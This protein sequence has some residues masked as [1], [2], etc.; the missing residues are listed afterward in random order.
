MKL[1]ECKKLYLEAKEA[2][3]LGNPIM[4][5]ATFDR[6]ENWISS[7]D[8][9]WE[10]LKKTG[11]KI[12]KKVEVEL[13]FFMPS[14]DKRYENIDEWF[15]KNP[16]YR[17]AYM[18][19]L[20]GCSVLLEYVKGKPNRL[21]TR[22]DGEHGKDISYFLPYLNIPG[23]IKHKKPICFRCEAILTKEDYAKKW[24]SEFDNPRNLVSGIFNRQDAHPAL[25]DVHLVV[26]G[27]FGLPQ[28]KG[29]QAAFKAGFETVYCKL[30]APREQ[31]KHFDL[32]RCGKYEADGVVICNPDFI[33]KYDSAEKPKRDIIAYKENVEFK[34]ATVTNIIYQ[35]SVNGRL[36]PKIEISPVVLSGATITF[37]TSHNAK[38][39]VEHG[40]GIGAR[41][42][43]T[44]SGDVIP[45]I[46]DV[47]QKGKIVYPNI[48]YTLEGVHFVSN[49]V[50]EEQRIKEISRFI[51]S[52]GVESVKGKTVNTLYEKLKI[53]SVR[54]L[55]LAIH[56]PRFLLRLRET[57]GEKKGKLIYD[58]L[59]PIAEKRFPIANLMIA[60][61]SFDAGVG[62]KRLTS[63]QEQEFDLLSLSSWEESAIKQSIVSPGI[64]E[65][66]AE[67]IANGLVAFHKFWERNKDLMQPPLP[68][69]KRKVKVGVLTGV[70]VTFTGYR[71]SEEENFIVSLGGTIVSFS[72][73]TDVLLYKEGGRKSSKIEKAGD[74]AMTFSQFKTKYHL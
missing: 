14:L 36:I 65:A 61:G 47:L 38:W 48:P 1:S 15:T 6:L 45:K 16:R 10:P 7:K 72:S 19:K 18:A 42:R 8:P 39:M 56:H 4:S 37:C 58:A 55:L 24:V 50:T 59:H 69:E 26:L 30:D 2:Y 57:F 22:G 33:Y 70:N 23:K 52:L 41:V 51:A 21:I 66:T 20:D 34:D 64:G 68:Y 25:K 28:Y 53:T 74:K 60:S 44:R 35:T 62:Y 17:W 63:L 27:V 67:I 40:I 49:E 46:I 73:K 13:P 32:I 12:G 11:V 43:I 5:D 31:V 71:S 29:L 54:R 9:D 3:Y